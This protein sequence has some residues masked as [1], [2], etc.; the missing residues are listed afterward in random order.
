MRVFQQVW[1]TF[2]DNIS[3]LK[4]GTFILSS[5][6]S[7]NNCFE[8][9]KKQT[10]TLGQTYLGTSSALHAGVKNSTFVTQKES[11]IHVSIIHL[12]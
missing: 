5:N 9:E 4:R 8:D 6:F 11:I 2:E 1:I 7:S 3:D 12:L 10:V